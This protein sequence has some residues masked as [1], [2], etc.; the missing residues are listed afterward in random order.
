MDTTGKVIHCKA[1]VAWEAEKP[2]SIEEVEIAPLKA[3]EV[4]VNIVATAVCHTNAYTLSGADPVGCIAVILGH[5]RAGIVESVGE[6]VTRVKAIDHVIPLY[7]PQC[8]E[9]YGAVV[10]TAKVEASS[11]RAVFGLGGV[12]L[13][14]IMG[15]KVADAA[16][17]IG[18]YINTDK[19]EKANKFEATECINP[20]DNDKPIRE[21]LIDLTNGGVDYSFECVGNVGVKQASLDACHK[22]WGTSIV[23]GV[24][25]SSRDFYKAL[26]T[27]H[28]MNL[29]R[30]CLWRLE[31]CGERPK[32]CE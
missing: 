21:V 12:G 2:L 23:V 9:C 22:G 24:A 28:W 5:E 14:V 30:H 29:E 15:C 32:T 1:A 4:W 19:L 6:G 31:E 11:N 3:H 17:I 16:Q 26:L 20:K 18:I 10:N 27:F 7:I 8:G 25:G 13:A